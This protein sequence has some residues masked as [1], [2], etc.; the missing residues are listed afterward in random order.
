MIGQVVYFGWLLGMLAQAGA[1][2][3]PADTSVAIWRLKPLGMDSSTADRLETLLRAETGRISG[4]GLQTKQETERLL[5]SRADLSACGGETACL[6]AIGKALSVDKLITGVIG[7]LGDDYT[8]DL[9]L[10]GVA[11]CRE[12]RRINEALNGREDLLIGAIRQALYKLVAPKLYVGSLSV[13]VPVEAAEVRVDG[14]LAG[15]TPLAGPIAG[16]R[17]GIHK[18]EIAKK[19]FSAFIEEVPIRF[20]QTTRVKVD[21]VKSVLTGLSYEKEAPKAVTADP[22]PV[23]VSAPVSEPKSGLRIAAWTTAGLAA[24]AV[25]TAGVLGWRVMVAERELEAAANSQ[26][27]YLNSSHVDIYER[28]QAYALGTNITWGLAGAAAVVSAVLFIVDLTGGEPEGAPAESGLV[29]EPPAAALRIS[30]GLGPDG[31]EV[32]L[33]VRF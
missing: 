2:P 13:E 8:F 18:L 21:M 15:V 29:A 32:Q 26:V 27:P 22:P 7:A 30:P 11:A 1:A 12:E 5:A 3:A 6:C 23:A 24:A 10:I 25:V 19:G 31:G 9:K 33:Q 14:K 28:G 4:I 20:M 17:P 16:L